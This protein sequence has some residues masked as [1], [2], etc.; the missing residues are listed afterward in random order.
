MSFIF[1]KIGGTNESSKISI[2]NLRNNPNHSNNNCFN[3]NFYT[4]SND[5]GRLRL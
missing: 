3:G 1:Q 5:T 2:Y 4:Y